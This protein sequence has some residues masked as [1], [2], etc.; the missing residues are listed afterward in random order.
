MFEI[1]KMEN[2]FDYS[3]VDSETAD[4]L[5]SCEY[6]MNGI[7]ED[8]RLKFGRVLKNVQ[9]KLSNYHDG[10]FVKWY[11]SGGLDKNDVYYSINLYEISR[12]L[13]NSKKDNFLNA[14]KTLQ[15]EVMKKNA[16]EELKQKVY[17]GD[18]TTN[19]EYQEM[20]RKLVEVEQAKRQA[21]SQAELERKER[22]RLEEELEN[23]EPEKIEVVPDDYHFYKG[24]YESTKR[25]SE[26]YKQDN[27]Q[28]R[29]ELN[30]VHDQLKSGNKD[31]IDTSKLEQLKEQEQK[32]TMRLDTYDKMH[33]IQ[34]L[35]ENTMSEVVK[36]KSKLNIGGDIE[37]WKIE[38][39]ERCLNEVENMCRELREILPNKNIIEGEIV[40]E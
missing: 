24:N 33:H 22:E 17:D 3:L 29:N 20:K 34:T 19:K 13:E 26:R 40:N 12:N 2:E 4:F 15:K 27:E 30:Q 23:V 6:E 10:V 36:N 39:F 38:E 37:V 11:E 25:L 35:L 16:P 21:E 5:R 9:E 7:A 18:I 1:E 32:I 28:L 14:P 31:K 8:A